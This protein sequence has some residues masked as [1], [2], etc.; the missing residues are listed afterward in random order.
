MKLLVKIAIAVVL[1]LALYDARAQ[2]R[3]VVAFYNVENLFDTINDPTRD[4]EQMLPLSDLEWDSAKYWRKVGQ[5]AELIERMGAPAIVGLAEVENRAVVE[6]VVHHEALRD[7]GYEVCHFDS[8]DRRGVDV[9]LIFRKGAFRLDRALPIVAKIESRTRDLLLVEGWLHGEPFSI[10]VVHWPSRIGG[11]RF[12]E[13]LRM[14]CARQT[15]AIVDSLLRSDLSRG[16]IVMGDMNDNPKDRSIREVFG[17]KPLP[18]KA[19][20]LE[21]RALYNP[22]VRVHSDRRGTTFYRGKWNMYDNIIVSGGVRLAEDSAQN[23]KRQRFS[24][25]GYI[26]RDSALVD[27]RLRPM[28]T[29]RGTEYVGGV[30]DHLPIYIVVEY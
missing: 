26:F 11:E 16:V 5:V 25:C 9:A 27:R 13:P 3:E 10:I 15:R 30:S 23:T 22:M 14:E 6:D 8:P 7:K 20:K 21:K 12:T 2:R 4:D 1:L 28:P 29:Y 18:S 19:E 24:G 17:A